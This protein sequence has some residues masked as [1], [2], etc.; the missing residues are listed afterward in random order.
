M[1]LIELQ[2]K[3]VAAARQDC[4]SDRVP[5]GFEQRIMA[6]LRARPALD[7]WAIW[8]GALWRAAAPCVAIMVVLAAWSLFSPAPSAPTSDFSQ[9]FESTVL[10]ASDQEPAPESLQ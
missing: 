8:A 1:N 10:A 9:Q 7:Q 3:L 5:Y 4:P 2:R 6:R